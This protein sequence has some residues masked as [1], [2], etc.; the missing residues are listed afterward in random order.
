MGNHRSDAMGSNENIVWVS[1]LFSR[2][3]HY[4]KIVLNCQ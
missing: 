2:L 3:L 4:L 1:L